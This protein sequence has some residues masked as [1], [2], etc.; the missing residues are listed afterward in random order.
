MKILSFFLFEADISYDSAPS[1]PTPGNY[2]TNF[3]EESSDYKQLELD[4]S[5]ETRRESS[6]EMFLSP[7]EFADT[8]PQKPTAMTV[9]DP[10]NST[11]TDDAGL[12]VNTTPTVETTISTPPANPTP[13]GEI[14]TTSVQNTPTGTGSAKSSVIRGSTPPVS[15]KQSPEPTTITP[16]GQTP[17]KPTP[18]GPTPFPNRPV[19]SFY[20]ILFLFWIHC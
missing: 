13:S 16:T 10:T 2:S 5:H 1:Y 20:L 8:T 19:T 6:T 14:L 3:S 12:V 4:T 7:D 15:Q 9:V 18:R 11:T 17:E